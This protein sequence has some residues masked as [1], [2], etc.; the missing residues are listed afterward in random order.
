MYGSADKIGS[1]GLL[2]NDPNHALFMAL[3]RGRLA[4]IASV[5]SVATNGTE[6]TAAEYG[7]DS[8]WGSIMPPGF[9]PDIRRASAPADLLH[10]IGLL[11][12]SG[13]ASAA[14][15]NFIRPSPL[16]VNPLQPGAQGQQ[17]GQQQGY[18]LRVPMSAPLQPSSSSSSATLGGGPYLPAPSSHSPTQTSSAVPSEGPSPSGTHLQINAQNIAGMMPPPMLPAQQQYQQQQQQQQQH[19]YAESSAV[20]PGSFPNVPDPSAYAAGLMSASASSTGG[21]GP[22]LGGPPTAPSAAAAELD[23][24]FDFVAGNADDKDQFAFLSDLTNDSG[25]DMV[26]VLV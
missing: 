10:N 17:Q 23:F 26:N 15:P 19:Q 22:E 8:E 21:S 14:N 13:G 18:D 7:S 16:A 6:A 20:L 4:S 11:G 1:S 5:N 24:G 25:S 12:I 3:E 9:D 2:E